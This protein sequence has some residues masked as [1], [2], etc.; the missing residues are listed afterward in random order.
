LQNQIFTGTCAKRI[1]VFANELWKEETYYSTTIATPHL[2]LQKKNEHDAAVRRHLNSKQISLKSITGSRTVT[3]HTSFPPTD[4]VIVSTTSTSTL[5]YDWHRVDL[6]IPPSLEEPNIGNVGPVTAFIDHVAL[7]SRIPNEKRCA[8]GKHSFNKSCSKKLCQTCCSK[9]YE[10]CAV[11]HHARAKPGGQSSA[12][13]RVPNHAPS[14][15]SPVLPG[16]VDAL[17]SVMKEG[18]CCYIAYTNKDPQEKR[19]RKIKPLEWVRYGKCFKALCFNQVPPINKT[20]N[21]H[22]VARIEE[23]EWVITTLPSSQGASICY[24]A[25]F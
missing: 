15:L 9:S 3:H 16:V 4:N 5:Q 13:A 1:D 8:C 12:V 24:A 23:N 19:A 6:E 11:T 22:K 2:W 21:T 7:P 20:F 17:N 10:P 25:L 18:K 14:S